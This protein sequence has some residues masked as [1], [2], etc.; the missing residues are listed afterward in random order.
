MPF[1]RLIE[2]RGIITHGLG[3]NAAA[4]EL[5]IAEFRQMVNQ[6]ERLYPLWL[7]DKGKAPAEAIEEIPD[8]K[9]QL[10]FRI[11]VCLGVLLML[12][13]AIHKNGNQYAGDLVPNL[14]TAAHVLTLPIAQLLHEVKKD[15][16][17]RG[18]T[19]PPEEDGAPAQYFTPDRRPT[20]PGYV[21]PVQPPLKRA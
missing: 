15:P 20:D 5:Y 17:L 4:H 1:T 16:I 10:I 11:R 6:V 14:T 18:W 2:A 3:E 13:E 21:G 9:D 8:T 19:P 7:I 12:E